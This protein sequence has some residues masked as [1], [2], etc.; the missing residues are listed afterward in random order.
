MKRRISSRAHCAS[1]S[2]AGMDKLSVDIPITVRPRTRSTTSIAAVRLRRSPIGRTASSQREFCYHNI[3]CEHTFIFSHWQ[4]HERTAS[5]QLRHARS[6]P[7]MMRTPRARCTVRS[8]YLDIVTQ[9]TIRAIFIFVLIFDHNCFRVL[10]SPTL[11]QRWTDDAT[12]LSTNLQL[13]ITVGS[14]FQRPFLEQLH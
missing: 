4:Q 2:Y 12:I 13:G 9:S 5:S 7:A 1:Q 8:E 14:L 10:K 6:L 3:K 11:H